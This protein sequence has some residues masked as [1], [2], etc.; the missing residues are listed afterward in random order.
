M[1]QICAR[2][3]LWPGD[4]IVNALQFLSLSHTC[5][6]QSNG[7]TQGRSAV[8]LFTCAR[9]CIQICA[10]YV[11]VRLC[12]FV[13]G[14]QALGILG[15]ATKSTEPKR[16]TMDDDAACWALFASNSMDYKIPIDRVVTFD[17]MNDFRY[18]VPKRAPP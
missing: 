8:V 18:R 15:A 11:P 17:E 9:V 4:I 5:A 14:A 1:C 7:V 16:L 6:S 10:R 12:G 2:D 3:A 13:T